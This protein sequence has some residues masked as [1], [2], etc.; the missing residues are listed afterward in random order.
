MELENPTCPWALDNLT[1][2]TEMNTDPFITGF[3][4]YLRSKTWYLR[5]P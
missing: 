5:I 1:G 3:A 4:S 2:G